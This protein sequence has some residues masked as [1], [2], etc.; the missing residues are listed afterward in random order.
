MVI[1]KKDNFYNKNKML[2]CLLMQCIVFVLFYNSLGVC[3]K[4]PK[5][6][7][8]H[9]ISKDKYNLILSFIKSEGKCDIPVKE[10]KRQY[11]SAYIYYWRHKYKLTSG[12]YFICSFEFVYSMLFRVW[13]ACI[14]MIFDVIC[15]IGYI[16]QYPS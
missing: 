9:T 2:M 7:Y 1:R 5:T 15:P 14:F 12:M 8:I 10:R 6:N 4:P 3:G 11:R 13:F 16:L